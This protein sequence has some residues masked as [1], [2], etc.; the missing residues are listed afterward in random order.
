MNAALLAMLHCASVQENIQN[1]CL[2]KFLCLRILKMFIV[3]FVVYVVCK[4]WNHGISN[5]KFWRDKCK[6][7]YGLEEDIGIA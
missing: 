1:G 6:L 5:F 2:G 4:S 3:N 7:F